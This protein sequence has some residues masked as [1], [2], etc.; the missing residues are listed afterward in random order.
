MKSYSI[1]ITMLTIVIVT[2]IPHW[3]RRPCRKCKE[4]ITEIPY[5]RYFND[6]NCSTEEIL[7]CIG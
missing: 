1:L 5:I 2:S 4:C 7:R 3:C 6:A